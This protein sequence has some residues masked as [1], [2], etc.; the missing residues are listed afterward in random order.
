ME[1]KLTANICY[2][3]G[4]YSKGSKRQ[5][6]FVSI[7][8]SVDELRDRF[9][10][11]AVKDLGVL[12]NKIIFGSGTDKNVVGFFHSRVAKRLIDLEKRE[13]HVFKIDNEFSRSYIAGMFDAAGHF[14]SDAVEIHN[15]DTDD[16]IMLQN[17]GV[18][19][20]GDKILNIVRFVSLIK[21]K[22]LLARQFEI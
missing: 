1:L 15:I 13:V 2:M 16:A 6:N 12:P 8:S 21:G 11:I 17:L 22:S 7:N 3:A 19:S 5:K 18:H 9:V 10:E 20:K 4:L 14:S